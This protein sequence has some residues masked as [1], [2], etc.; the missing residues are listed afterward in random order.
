MVTNGSS[1]HRRKMRRVSDVWHVYAQRLP[2]CCVPLATLNTVVA[3]FSGTQRF[4]QVPLT[5]CPMPL[6]V[7]FMHILIHGF[8]FVMI[9]A[10]TAPR[11]AGAEGS[12]VESS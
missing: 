6:F 8:G 3:S 2:P 9:S 5:A 12:S 10:L 4:G 11:S 7:W 1:A